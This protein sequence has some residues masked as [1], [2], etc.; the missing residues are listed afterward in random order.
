MSLYC[1]G[2]AVKTDEEIRETRYIRE[3]RNQNIRLK[4]ENKRL[5]KVNQ[6]LEDQIL[7]IT[8]YDEEKAVVEPVAHSSKPSK[9]DKSCHACGSYDTEKFQAGIYY[10]I[11]CHSCLSKKKIETDE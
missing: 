6:Q 5:R 11:R 2:Q 9:E 1:K 10:F 4:R 8:G 7:M 3:L